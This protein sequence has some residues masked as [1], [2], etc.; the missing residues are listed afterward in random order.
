MKCCRIKKLYC[1][2]TLGKQLPSAAFP[3][4]SGST[5][6]GGGKKYI[7]GVPSAA[8]KKKKIG[9]PS[10]PQ[11]IL[12][13]PHGREGSEYVFTFLNTYGFYSARTDTQNHP[14]AH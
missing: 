14:V 4:H 11:M 9:M 6:L 7:F 3:S 2:K 5:A 8:V 1:P 13:L 12:K 10:A